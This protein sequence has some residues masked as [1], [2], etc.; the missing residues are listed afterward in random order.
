MGLP[1]HALRRVACAVA[2]GTAALVAQAA[3]AGEPQISEA[4]VTLTTDDAFCPGEDTVTI[5]GEDLSGGGFPCCL[6]SAGR[7]RHFRAIS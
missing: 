1:H 6:L 7:G 5:V 2:I 3:S 4:F